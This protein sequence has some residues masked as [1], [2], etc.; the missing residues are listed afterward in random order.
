MSMA[1]PHLVR[2]NLVVHATSQGF[3]HELFYPD[4]LSKR[5]KIDYKNFLQMMKMM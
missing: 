4:K 3:I 5:D 1:S 2:W